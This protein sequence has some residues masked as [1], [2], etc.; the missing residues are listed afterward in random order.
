MATAKNTQNFV[1]NTVA[2]TAGD[3]TQPAQGRVLVTGDTEGFLRR[4]VDSIT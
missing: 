2:A 4:D 3:I 1:I